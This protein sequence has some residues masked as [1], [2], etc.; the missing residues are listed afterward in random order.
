M[1]PEKIKK[2][3]AYRTIILGE[4]SNRQEHTEI[5]KNLS[6]LCFYP[7]LAIGAFLTVLTYNP[8]FLVFCLLGYFVWLAEHWTTC[9]N[10]IR[11]KSKNKKFFSRKSYWSLDASTIPI[12]RH[13]SSHSLL[14]GSLYRVLYGYAPIWMATAYLGYWQESLLVVGLLVTAQFINDIGHLA[15]DGYKPWEWFF[16]RG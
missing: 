11:R 5:C 12:H 8:Q 1:I 16:G 15:A 6:T 7:G 2:S 10:D 13:P 9:D 3:A 14:P 4:S